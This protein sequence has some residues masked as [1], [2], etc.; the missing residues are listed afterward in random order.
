VSLWFISGCASAGAGEAGSE[1]LT[2]ASD[3]D[4]QVPPEVTDHTVEERPDFAQTRRPRVDVSLDLG[5]LLG[6]EPDSYEMSVRR[7]AQQCYSQTL[8][9]QKSET[10]GSIVYEVLV[11]RN[12]HVAGTDVMSSGL[13]NSEVSRCVERVIGRLNFDVPVRNRPVYRIFFRLDFYLETI[14]PGNPPV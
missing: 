5:S 12:G 9:V 8:Q 7:K 4:R 10:E 13:N 1:E 11:T 3:V 6:G 14:V 2:E